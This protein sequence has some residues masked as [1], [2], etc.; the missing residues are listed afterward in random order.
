MKVFPGARENANSGGQTDLLLHHGSTDTP[1]IDIVEVGIGLGIIADNLSYSEF[2]GYFGFATVNYIIQVRDETGITK[3]AAYK[4]PLATL[5]LQ[6][7]AVTI[8]A[9][10]FMEPGNNSNGP[11]FGLFI[12]KAT[13]GAF[14]KLPEYAPKARLQ[15]IHNSADTA[16]EVVDVWLNQELILDNFA[17]HTASPFIDAPADEQFT[18]AIK[19]PQSVDPYNPLFF[20][21]YTLTEGETYILVADGIIS[22]TGYDPFVPFDIAVYPTGREEA[23]I[24]GRTDVLVH[25]GST[26]APSVDIIEIGLGAGMLVDN[27]DYAAF[28]SYLEL[29]TIDYILEVRDETGATVLGKFRAPLETSGLLDKAVTVVASGFINPAGNSNGTAFGLWAATPEG[30][31]MI[32][33]PLYVPSARVQIIHNS[34]DASASVVDVWLNEELLLDNFAFR[35]ATPFLYIPSETD[36][37]IAVK[38]PDSQDPSNPLWSNSFNLTTDERYIMVANGIISPSGYDP[39]QPFN[40]ILYTGAVEDAPVGTS[41]NVLVFHGATDAPTFDLVVTDGA[42]VADN[43]SYGSFD[44]YTELP[45]INYS[46]D[47]TGEDGSNHMGNFLAPLADLNLGGQA[48]TILASG[49][50]NPLNNSN[51]P[52]LALLA[53]Q[54]DGTAVLFS[55]TIGINESAI[56]AS[57]FSIF[58][59]PVKENLNISFELKGKSSLRLE[60]L[61]MTGKTVRSADL[62]MRNAGVYSE[63]INVDGLTSGIYLLNVRTGN[64]VSGKKLI[65]E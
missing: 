50:V 31:A 2:A 28:S 24:S 52:V 56:E 29:P 17:F 64:G 4:L 59:N 22:P 30:G 21:N 36:I 16:A 54:L 6:G 27:L 5:G 45:T 18:I 55:N 35:T 40:M 49:F 61:D 37:T 23:N 3:I 9:S 60:I 41:T 63:N 32:E 19:G 7:D 26:D 51:G 12:A 47:L 42:M 65:V 48:L 38:G 53:V 58:P 33:F 8:L 13:G 20:H 34:A 14:L 44:G 25:H 57:S 11:E 10:G 15:V 62:G 43:L 1:T 39:G 46:L